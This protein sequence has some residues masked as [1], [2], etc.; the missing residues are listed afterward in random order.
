MSPLVPIQCGQGG[1][2]LRRNIPIFYS[3]LM[4]TGVN[5]LL[6]MVS[7]SFQVF[8][9]ARI[10]AAGIGLLQLVLSVGSLAMTAGIAGIRTASMYLTAEELGKKRPG[11]VI[12]V[13]SGCLRYSLMFSCSVGAVLYFGAPWICE[14][15]ICDLQALEAVRLFAVFLPVCCITGV[16][17]G[18]FTA[19]NRIGTL[20]AVEV[21][22]Q[23]LSMSATIGALYFW[24]GDDPGKA[25]MAVV[26]GSG[27]GACLTLV[28]LAILRTKEKAPIN[29]RIS[30][31]QRLTQT[32]LPLAVA[33]D[34]KAGITTAE[35]L[36]VPKR[37]ALFSGTENPLALFGTVCGM[38]FPVLMFPACI[39]FGLT[40]LLI[41]ELARC[42]A[43]GSQLRIRYLVRRSLRLALLYGTVCGC[44]MYLCSDALCL[45]L[46]N[47]AEAGQ[48]LGWFAILTVM[49]YCDIITDAM[50]KGLG[51]QK[52]SVRYN[53]VT[54]VMDLVMLYFLLPSFGISG[55]FFSFTLSHAVNFVLSLRRLLK[56]SKVHIPFHVPVLT[57]C[58][59]VVSVYAAS[60]LSSPI[61]K[62][63]SFLLIFAC[64]LV[65][66][67][68]ISRDDLRW[69]RGLI[70]KKN[71]SL[72]N[73]TGVLNH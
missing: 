3:A 49:L 27:I 36:M 56:I 40:E 44:V 12:W 30:L 38:V 45:V 52:A 47:S 42:N 9:S 20:A 53:I 10:G 8:L 37:L 71:A 26:A 2:F 59:A 4:L 18:Y 32:A 23:A 61:L 5:L 70:Y 35:N 43:A 48:Y 62:A 72:P 67:R 24:A 66:L 69:V 14:N 41:P 15:W 55:Y 51:Q 68:V 46:Y 73:K 11:N 1:I 65:L 28:S 34:L 21:A 39:L 13:I 22:E 50:I 17:V 58:C 64:L 16:M 33:D 57:L 6:R 54:S 31:S 29:W 19:A 25:C 63:V 60:Y 7:T